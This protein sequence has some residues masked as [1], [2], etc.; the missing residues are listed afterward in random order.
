MGCVH[1]S[2]VVG[3]TTMG[4]LVGEAGPWQPSQVGC[5]AVPH[6]V[7]AGLLEG[8][9][10]FPHGWLHSLGWCRL[11]GGWEITFKKIG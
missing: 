2:V 1:T 3:L 6:V 5:D 9:V 8:G 4:A 11:T 7:G 10:G